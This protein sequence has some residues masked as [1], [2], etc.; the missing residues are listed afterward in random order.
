MGH[1]FSTQVAPQTVAPRTDD[2][3]FPT[4]PKRLT[5]AQGGVVRSASKEFVAKLTAIRCEHSDCNN[6]IFTGARPDGTLE[7]F[8]VMAYCGHY[9]CASHKKTYTAT[10]PFA[11]PNGESSPKKRQVNLFVHDEVLDDF[12]KAISHKGVKCFDCE[13]W[14]ARNNTVLCTKY[15]NENPSNEI[16][17]ESEYIEAGMW[18]VSLDRTQ[19]KAG[20]ALNQC[21]ICHKS[22]YNPHDE[23]R[24]MIVQLSICHHIAHKKCSEPWLWFT[25]GFCPESIRWYSR[26]NKKNMNTI[27]YEISA[28]TKQYFEGIQSNEKRDFFYC[29]GDTCMQ[30]HPNTNRP[31]SDGFDLQFESLPSSQYRLIIP[32]LLLANKKLSFILSQLVMALLSPIFRTHPDDFT[33]SKE[34]TLVRSASKDFV[35]KLIEI[36]CQHYICTNES[37]RTTF[38]TENLPVIAYCG[39]YICASHENATEKKD[40]F[41]MCHQCGSYFDFVEEYLKDAVLNDFYKAIAQEGFKCLGCKDRHPKHNTVF[42]HEYLPKDDETQYLCVWCFAKGEYATFK[43]QSLDSAVRQEND[44]EMK[45]LGNDKDID[46]NDKQLKSVDRTQGLAGWALNRCCICRQTLYIP[47]EEVTSFRDERSLIVH[48]ECDHIGHKKCADTKRFKNSFECQLC[49]P[50]KR[51]NKKNAVIR[52]RSFPT[53]YY[54]SGIKSA[55]SDFFD[56][57]ECAQKHPNSNRLEE[58]YGVRS[59]SKELVKKLIECTQFRCKEKFSATNLPVMAYCGHYVCSSHENAVDERDQFDKCHECAVKSPEQKIFLEDAVLNEFYKTIAQEGFKC[60]RCKERHPK[61]NTI[62]CP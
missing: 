23:D 32:S 46:E 39:H 11:C 49:R 52:E 17:V 34:K 54:F 8:P 28:Q 25:C 55:D 51:Y 27:S 50:P 33:D 14:H 59:A 13:E 26:W 3:I 7:N 31:K 42:C 18:L 56:C 61:H 4:R 21:C 57:E 40:K 15:A 12:Y 48:L 30:V 41:S 58:I 60:L 53:K 6:R 47:C 9:I 45:I 1:W 38:S 20:W 19:E 22:L 37:K 5:E 24:T 62:F 29:S 43:F 10:K 35:K 2:S 16:T 36:T 44:I